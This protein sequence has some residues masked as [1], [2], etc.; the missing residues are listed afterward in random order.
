MNLREDGTVQT[1]QRLGKGLNCLPGGVCLR[2][3]TELDRGHQRVR[4]CVIGVEPAG[5]LARHKGR[6]TE[7]QIGV[8]QMSDEGV[9]GGL[10]TP[11]RRSRFQVELAKEHGHAGRPFVETVRA[12]YRV[13]GGPQASGVPV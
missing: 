3:I 10:K 2:L 1:T 4:S 11:S 7:R 5:G 6:G 9:P 12:E 13:T 8:D